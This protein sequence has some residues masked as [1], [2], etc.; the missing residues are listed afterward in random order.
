[1]QRYG[2]ISRYFFELANRLSTLEGSS[3]S[4]VAPLYI[5]NYL[6]A[7]AAHSFTYGRYVPYNFA[8]VRHAVGIAN[9]IAAPQAWSNSDADIVH[10]TYFTLVPLGRGTRR[11]VTVYDMIHEIFAPRLKR[12]RVSAAKRAAVNRA[13][14]VI[15]ISETTRRDLVR[16][17]DVDPGRT[18][19]VHLGYS[20]TAQVGEPGAKESQTRPSL[21]YVGQRGGYKN[22]R[23]L[24]EALSNS[25]SLGEF[26]L[27]A[28]GGSPFSTSEHREIERLGLSERVRYMTG[29]DDRLAESYQAAVAFVYPSMYEGFGIPPLEAMSHGC[30][31]V[32]SNAG[33]I[34][35][36]V[37]NAGEYFDPSSAEDLRNTLERVALD[38]GLRRDLRT[39]G[40]KRIEAFSWDRCAEET[41]RIYQ[42]LV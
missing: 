26:E 40:Y 15:C 36:V 1:M 21:L 13:D 37:G 5:N 42:E 28:F 19:V 31:V 18:S 25:R 12:M 2:G 10:E 7:E 38:D 32:C 29:S 41:A 35:E 30:P 17:Y 39:Q 14:H 33:A 11:V 4:V 8:G 34:P 6:T 23:T 16:L 27:V 20:L 3:V 9:R 24:L 22:F